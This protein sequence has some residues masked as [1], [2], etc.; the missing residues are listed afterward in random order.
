M[1][2]RLRAGPKLTRWRQVVTEQGARE[3]V[4]MINDPNPIHYDAKAVANLG[5]GDRPI[6]PGPAN[7]AYF[8]NML[9]SCFPKA[10]ARSVKVRL[11]GTIYIGDVVEVTGS[12]VSVHTSHRESLVR[13]NLA[14][15][16]GN[17]SKI[18]AV[19]TADV[20]LPPDAG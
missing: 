13:C 6:N 14:L 11:T 15:R 8:Y 7:I 5:L 19:A 1:T 18:A 12:I 16:G 17:P 2:K 10:M 9:S 3:W 20:V 4:H